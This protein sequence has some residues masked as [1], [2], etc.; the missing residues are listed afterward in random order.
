MCVY[1]EILKPRTLFGWVGLKGQAG[2]QGCPLSYIHTPNPIP[3]HT[4]P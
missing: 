2:R 1:G 3:P 4:L